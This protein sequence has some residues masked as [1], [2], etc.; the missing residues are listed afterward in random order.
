MIAQGLSEQSERHP[1]TTIPDFSGTPAGVPG[2]LNRD[3]GVSRSAL[4]TWL[5]FLHRSAVHMPTSLKV[6][7][8]ISGKAST[9]GG[10]GNTPEAGAIDVDVWRAPVRVV[11]YIDGVHSEF[12]VLRFR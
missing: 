6:Q 4:H 11:E 10:G 8:N 1:W 12:E 9:S 2:L 7:S 5:P 3:P